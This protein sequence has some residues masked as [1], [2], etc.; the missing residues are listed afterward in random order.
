MRRLF[1]FQRVFL[2]LCN[3]WLGAAMHASRYGI[4]IVLIWAVL[5]IPC[6]VG[7]AFLGSLGKVLQQPPSGDGKDR[8]DRKDGKDDGL[9]GQ[10]SRAETNTGPV[11]DYMLGREVAA[12]VIGASKPVAPEAPVSRYVN[13]VCRSLV[14]ASASP[15]QY[16]PYTCIVL[17]DAE[18]NAFAAPGGVIFITTG[19]LRFLRDEDELATVLGHEV[20]HVQFRHGAVSVAQENVNNVLGKNFYGADGKDNLFGSMLGQLYGNILNGYSMEMEAE[21]DANGMRMAWE[22]GYAPQG[23]PEILERFK[24]VKNDYGGAGYPED[25]ARL[26]R[27]ALA[28]MSASF[29]APSAER[30][31]RYRAA[32]S[33]L[34]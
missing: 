29:P 27:E 13:Q 5:L 31:A 23:F 7:H 33:S 12:R 20:S 24:S 21:A 25:R 16:H 34:R 32:V 30:T 6:G 11:Y 2:G 9:F 10:L 15:Y 4:L 26:A 14:L 22:A 1:R 3:I 17:E 19:M 18:L 28:A 8:K